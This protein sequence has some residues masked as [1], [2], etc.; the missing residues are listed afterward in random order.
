MAM[1]F[2]AKFAAALAALLLIPSFATAQEQMQAAKCDAVAAPPPALAGWSS[3]AGMSAASKIDGVAAAGLTIDRAAMVALHP[4]REVS[5][6]TQPDKPG[7]SVAHGG[8]LGVTIDKAGTYQ[9]NLSSG[10]WIDLV[11]DGKSV[12]STAHAPGP[13]C[14]GIRKTVQFPLQPGRYV[15]QISANA[16]DSIAVLVSKVS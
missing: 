10:A 15:L 9:V 8:L 5:F 7:G 11:R 1:K 16:D 2:T 4:T 6:I 3:K 12:I 13:Q 14:T